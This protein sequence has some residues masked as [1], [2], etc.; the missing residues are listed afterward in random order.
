MQTNHIPPREQKMI[1]HLY[2]LGL[3]CLCLSVSAALAEGAQDYSAQ[4]QVFKDS[5]VSA[6]FFQNAYGYAYFP[7]VGKGGVG[8]GGAFGKGQVYRHGRVTGTVS[9]Y[10]LSVGLQLGGQAFSEIIF[11]QNKH[12]YDQFTNG[13]FELDATASAV[14]ITAAAQASAKSEAKRS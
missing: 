1:R 14:A 11:F 5:P 4:L 3:L 6:R 13:S 7:T 12:A 9:L 10:K 2:R 8:I